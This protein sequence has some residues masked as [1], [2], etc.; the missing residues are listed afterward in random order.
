M[1]LYTYWCKR[2]MR[3]LAA[4]ANKSYKA[5]KNFAFQ[6]NVPFRSCISKINSTLIQKVEDLDTVMR[7]C[8]VS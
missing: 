3:F 4:V 8:N 1:L 7:N 5:E 2:D 6:N